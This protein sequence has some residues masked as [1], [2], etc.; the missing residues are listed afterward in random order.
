MQGTC[1]HPRWYYVAAS[2]SSFNNR[3]LRV[4][5]QKNKGLKTFVLGSW[6]LQGSGWAFSHVSRA[7]HSSCR[8][9]CAT[10]FFHCPRGHGVTVRWGP[11]I[12][13][14]WRHFPGVQH[15]NPSAN[16][17]HFWLGTVLSAFGT[18]PAK[19]TPIICVSSPLKAVDIWNLTLRQSITACSGIW[20]LSPWWGI[21][22]AWRLPG[23]RG[24]GEH[25]IIASKA[26]QTET[27]KWASESLDL[28]KWSSESSRS[29]FRH[30]LVYAYLRSFNNWYI[31]KWQMF[32]LKQA[33]AR[34]YLSV[35]FNISFAWC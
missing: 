3:V 30:L 31:I 12:S 27:E 18:V 26:S 28:G 14:P 10:K 5:L 16:H 9:G 2:C 22:W 17:Q 1:H 34:S 19:V 23:Q 33:G 11:S 24:Y 15:A 7:S 4:N 32:V 6:A 29:E 35:C 13:L 20:D 25:Y 8:A 21:D